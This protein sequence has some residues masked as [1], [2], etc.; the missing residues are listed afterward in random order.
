[1]KYLTLI[2][3]IYLFA[4]NGAFGSIHIIGN[5]T[6]H[7]EYGDYFIISRGDTFF[8]DTTLIFVKYESLA[9]ADD[10]A[11]IESRYGLTRDYEYC[12]GWVSYTYNS[13]Q[14]FIDLSIA[15]DNELSINMIDFN[16]S[17]YYLCD[18]LEPDDPEYDQGDDQW[19]LDKI[20]V[21]FAWTITTGDPNIIVAILDSG[22]DWEH[23]DLGPGDDDYS[24][25][26]L[27]ENENNGGEDAW[28][29]W[30]EP[31]T[32]DG[33][34]NDNNDCTDDWKGWGEMYNSEHF[35]PFYLGNDVRNYDLDSLD[36]MYPNQHELNKTWWMHGTLIAGIIGA[37]TNNGVDIS[38]IAGGWNSKGTSMVLFKT[39]ISDKNGSYANRI[40]YGI[41]YAV[42]KLPRNDKAH[43]IEMALKAD[44][45][46]DAL[47][48]ALIYAYNQGVF[49]VAA[50]GNGGEG[51]VFFPASHE[52]VFAVGATDVDDHVRDDSNFGP[53]QDI[54]A[55][56]DDIVHLVPQDGLVGVEISTGR[57]SA[58]SAMVAGTAALM[59]SKNPNLTNDS[60]AAILRA[61]ADKGTYYTYDEDGHNDHI[62]HGRLNAQ[63]AV[64]MAWDHENDEILYTDE[65][66]DYSKSVMNSVFVKSGVTL[67]ITAEIQFGPEAK[68]LIE[69]G[70][71]VIVDGGTLTN[72]KCCHYEDKF[73]PG[74]QVWGTR[75]ASQYCIS[76]QYCPQG[77]LILNGATIENA[78][79]AVDLWKPGENDMTGG[80]IDATDAIFLNNAKSIHAINYR[81]F[82]PYP[83]YQ[84]LD[85]YGAFKNCTF[86][87]T[88]Q[89]F[90]GK[91][92]YKHV[93]LDRVRGIRF[94]GCSFSLAPGL[95]NV[96]E[97]NLGIAAYN[98]GFS[99][100][101]VC[102]SS[103][104]P[105]EEYDSC[106]FNG[107]YWAIGV[108]S[109]T[110][111][112]Y[113]VL[114]G[115]AAFNDNYTGV[116]ISDADYAVILNNYFEIGYG[117]AHVGDDGYGIGLGIDIYHGMGFAVENNVFNKNNDAEEGIYAG[118]RVLNCPSVYDIIYKNDF[119]GLSFGNYAEGT[120]RQDPL[121][122]A[123]GVEYQCNTNARNAVDFIVTDNRPEN[124][125]IRGPQGSKDKS[126]GNIFS[127]Y[128]PIV[129]HFRNEGTHII[130]YYYCDPCTDE[131][132]TR[133][134]TLRPE[135]FEKIIS[136]ANTCPDHY[137]GSGHIELTAGE[138]Q[139]K[140]ADYV[141]NL[142]DYNSVSY[143]YESLKDGGDTEAELTDIQTAQPDDMWA[144][145][146]QLLGHSPH[147]SQEVIRAVSDRTDVFP[148]DILLEILSA[149]PDELNKDT[150]LSYL[151]Q[152]EDPLPEYMLD[153]LRQ[154]VEGITYKTI[155][156]DELAQ[157]HAGKTQA[158][159]DIIRSIASDNIFDLND[160][161][162]WLDNLGGLEA[163]KQIIA[164]YLSENDTA[165]VIIL[166]NLLP[167]LYGLEGENLEDYNDFKALVEMQISWMAEN[168][169]V[170]ELDSLDIAVLETFAVD[171][172]TSAGNIA[173][174]ILTYGYNY[175]FY[176]NMHIND[177]SFYKSSN[178]SYFDSLNEVLDL[179]I[180]AKPN[181]ADTWVAFNYELTD[182]MSDGIIKITDIT[183]KVIQQFPVSGKIGQQVWDTRNVKPGLYYYVLTVSGISKSGKVIIN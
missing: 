15:L 42:D 118:I 33:L 81:N 55:P 7:F 160:Y 24:N 134:Y 110:L 5:D 13:N 30:N 45:N 117:E 22:F 53:E 62:G 121:I 172:E 28:D 105:C 46:N 60:I 17:I 104:I 177:S 156:E 3:F 77:K 89:Y 127:R 155:L 141:Q 19:Y 59:L 112:D 146:T 128:T 148:D 32:G 103:T 54:C 95:E 97:W 68:L 181:P 179:T 66:W 126:S 20:E 98:A 10:K 58:A 27:N 8:I 101:P 120:N 102:M 31:T 100:L 69:Q 73:W 131:E 79:T 143:L 40:A 140:E 111:I 43:I 135:Y 34:D 176:N 159:Q 23:D 61:S 125:M 161:R 92:F 85:Y 168:K 109:T 75:N 122:D 182:D 149:N 138:R 71:T 157:Y 119:N 49:L 2:I 130:N 170:D 57:T 93:D 136:E 36:I 51:D 6:I 113:P 38:G 164:S 18:G 50:S 47:N 87:L 150:L 158:A 114:V 94:R 132:P 151:E 78:V 163:D 165:S 166:L 64:C 67:T 21:P 29:E 178:A 99:V 44:A 16:T 137:G 52:Y 74:I 169:M 80:I 108:F 91:T 175:H 124:A 56:G 167:S 70:G 183:G 4:L 115:Y 41:C 65:L 133:I 153:I 152:K 116:F 76:G 12:Y 90:S 154:A 83:P 180:S 96:S 35:P 144:L 139:E 25:I 106:R 86:T 147:L 129:W 37:K 26:Y 107:F 123:M 171:G 72:M 162:N 9:D 145:R 142:S 174:N 82:N 39:G 173:R 14:K 84:E 11:A 1:M 48:D 88:D 63:T